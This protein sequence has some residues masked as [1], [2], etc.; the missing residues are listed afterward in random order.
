[1]RKNSSVIS[2]S[3][4]DKL[5]KYVY[6]ILVETAEFMYNGKI[7]AIPLAA[8]KGLACKY[9]RFSDICGNGDG[10]I[11]RDIDAEKLKEAEEILGGKE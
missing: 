10:L 7:E 11:Y 6:K 4:M 9:C 1:M 3:G 8:A 2:Y 5:K